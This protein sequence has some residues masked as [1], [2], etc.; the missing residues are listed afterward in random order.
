MEKSFR[1]IRRPII[2]KVVSIIKKRGLLTRYH[3]VL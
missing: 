2:E 3:V 1:T